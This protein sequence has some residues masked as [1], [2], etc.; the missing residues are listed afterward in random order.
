[1]D[2]FSPA[3]G[4]SCELVDILQPPF[5]GPLTYAPEKVD[6]YALFAI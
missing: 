2:R 6:H 1:M 4:Y 5:P 3:A